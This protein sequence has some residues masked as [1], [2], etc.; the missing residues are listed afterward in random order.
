VLDASKCFGR[1]FSS[2]I[3]ERWFSC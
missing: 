2:K 1:M 3:W